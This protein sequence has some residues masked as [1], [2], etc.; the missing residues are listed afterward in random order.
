MRGLVA[1]GLLLAATAG[2]VQAAESPFR[3]YADIDD[4]DD[5][6][7]DRA[8]P[9]PWTAHG[10]YFIDAGGAPAKLVSVSGTPIRVF[11]DHAILSTTS[12]PLPRLGVQAVAAGRSSITFG[13]ATY[14]V[15]S[16]EVVARERSGATVDLATSHASLSRTLPPDLASQVDGAVDL[17]ALTWRGLFVSLC[18]G[19]PLRQRGEIPR[20]SAGPRF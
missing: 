11:S 16:C 5:G 20:E 7:E 2:P 19:E 8:T 14:E 15:V 4:D 3:L 6:V 1:A 17:D 12:A 18:Y 13:A 10:A 9:T